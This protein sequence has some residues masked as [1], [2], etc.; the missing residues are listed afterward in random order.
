MQ[1]HSDH[2]TLQR[3]RT[4]R[5]QQRAVHLVRDQRQEMRRRVAHDVRH[6][7]QEGMRLRP[8]RQHTVGELGDSVPRAC[9][10]VD[11]DEDRGEE[12]HVQLDAGVRACPAHGGDR[13][14]RGQP[15]VE[16]RAAAVADVPRGRDGA[17]LGVDCGGVWVGLDADVEA[18]LSEETRDSGSG[19]LDLGQQM[20][21]HIAVLDA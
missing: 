8:P 5:R 13:D 15:R 17:R 16:Q 10:L 1:R 4:Q 19:E 3:R 20:L 18:C 6:A 12:R 11:A 7:L 14:T 9:K 2:I 21:T